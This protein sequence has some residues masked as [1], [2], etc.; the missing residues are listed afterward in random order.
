MSGLPL[1]CEG[2]G[3]GWLGIDLE[4]AIAEATAAFDAANHAFGRFVTYAVRP[5]NEPVPPEIQRVRETL[6]EA[7]ISVPQQPSVEEAQSFLD[8]LRA[9]Y[10]A[11]EHFLSDPPSRYALEEAR[12]TPDALDEAIQVLEGA[13]RSAGEERL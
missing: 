5:H 9:A 7:A 3:S 6:Q 13:L 10:V 4:D 12:P 2:R 8:A 11:V 1:P